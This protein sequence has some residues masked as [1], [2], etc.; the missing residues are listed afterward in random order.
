MTRIITR[1]DRAGV[2]TEELRAR[3]V[4]E[5]RF[6]VSS[7]PFTDVDLAL[8]DIVDCVRV[9]GEWH[10]DSVVVRGG[11]ST[12]RI[13]PAGPVDV[14][15]PLLDAGCRVEQGPAGLLAVSIGPDGPYQGIT[16]WLEGLVEAGLIDLSPGY[17]AGGAL[18]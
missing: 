10:V 15:G 13:L 4:G 11:N 17:T 7:I 5:G 8:G 6:I 9:D 18:D 3:P 12:L 2:D 16:A 14:A 1:V